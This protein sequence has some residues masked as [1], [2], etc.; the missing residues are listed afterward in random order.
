[1]AELS[2]L[3]RTIKAFI[4]RGE[5]HYVAECLDISVVTQGKTLDETIAN[6]QEAVGL[7]LE[8]EDPAE[9]GLVSNPT[10]VVVPVGAEL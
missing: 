6:L 7:H 3:R 9:F 10:L 4:H 8:G 2:T 5:S 1:M